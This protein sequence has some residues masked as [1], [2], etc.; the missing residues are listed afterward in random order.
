MDERDVQ[1]VKEQRHPAK[2]D[3]EPAERSDRSIEQRQR[4]DGRSQRHQDIQERGRILLAVNK[5]KDGKE[6]IV[7]LGPRTGIL[8][9]QRVVVP[10]TGNRIAIEVV[11]PQ[12]HK[13]RRQGDAEPE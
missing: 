6:W 5:R 11:G 2:G 10:G 13:E 7:V 9:G 4:R 3:E 8:M 1:Q 12:D